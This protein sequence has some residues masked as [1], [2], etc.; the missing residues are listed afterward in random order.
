M[1]RTIFQFSK[2]LTVGLMGAA[3]D[4]GT[5]WFLTRKLSV[6]LIPA[7]L[8]SAALGVTN[9]FFWNKYWTFKQK[10]HS[11]LK[12]ELPKFYTI[13]ILAYV[14]QQVALPTLV[15]LPLEQ[16]VGDKEDL[17]FKV[18]LMGVVGVGTF[19]L[20]RAWTFRSSPE[21]QPAA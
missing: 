19:F 9:N 6:D 4:L 11:T 14:F 12:R 10:S 8:V 17:V 3:L 15:L 16:I 18:M 1:R 21:K 2:Y 7:N 20:N 5:F 13:A